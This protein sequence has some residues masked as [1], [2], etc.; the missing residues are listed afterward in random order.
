MAWV[1]S[2][3]AFAFRR[4]SSH[5]IYKSGAASLKVYAEKRQNDNKLGI[6]VSPLT[7]NT[8][9]CLSNVDE[10][11]MGSKWKYGEACVKVNGCITKKDGN[12][13]N[14]I[15]CVITVLTKDVEIFSFDT[16]KKNHP[17]NTV[18]HI[19]EGKKNEI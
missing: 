19:Q 6:L 14:K 16:D 10:V 9:F 15:N 17:L 11:C 7:P 3:E 18:I 13:T 4:G 2:L 8:T 1:K 12:M 5:T